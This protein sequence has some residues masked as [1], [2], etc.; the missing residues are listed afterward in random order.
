MILTIM[1]SSLLIIGLSTMFFF[2]QMATFHQT[3]SSRGMQG[4]SV[5]EQGI[6]Y[7]IQQLSAN[8]GAWTNALNGSFAGTDCNTN[9]NIMSPTGKYHFRLHCSTGTTGN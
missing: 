5:A 1:I 7:A 3:A 6:Y 9:A 4:Q 2:N 8:T